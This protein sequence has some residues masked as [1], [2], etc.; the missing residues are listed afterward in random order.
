M[1]L[2]KQK[3]VPPKPVYFT[4]AGY[5]AMLAEQIKLKGERPHAV[6][7][8]RKARELGDLSENGYYKASRAKL[9]QVDRRLRELEYLLRYG[10][11]AESSQNEYVEIGSTVVL[12][13]E[14]DKEITYNIV[15]GYESDPLEGKLSHISP[16]GKQLMKKRAGETV[17]FSAPRGEMAYTILKIV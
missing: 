2:A 7:E 4:Q 5:D 16:L 14:Q 1:K 6:D 11:I 15:G 10:K 17:I 9:S 3:Y 8:L 13:T 12:Q